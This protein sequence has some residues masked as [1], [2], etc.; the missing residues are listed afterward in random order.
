MFG[1]IDLGKKIKA[2]YTIKAPDGMYS[3]N[4]KDDKKDEKEQIIIKNEL[5][6]II[7]DHYHILIQLK[8]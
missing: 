8:K 6:K 2:V 5:E 1:K 7:K 3:A 4:K